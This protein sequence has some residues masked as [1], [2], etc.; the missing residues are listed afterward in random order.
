MRHHCDVEWADTL[1][2]VGTCLL[3]AKFGAHGPHEASVIVGCAAG[4]VAW[5]TR[6]VRRALKLAFALAAQVE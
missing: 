2:N 5:Q 3:I 4:L 1:R 6:P